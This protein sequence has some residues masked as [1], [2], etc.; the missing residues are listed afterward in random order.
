MYL[1]K[2]SGDKTLSL[3]RK[4]LSL[5]IH[6]G[7][8]GN[9]I[10]EFDEVYILVKESFF[11]LHDNFVPQVPPQPFQQVLQVG[12]VTAKVPKLVLHLPIGLQ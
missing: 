9:Q 6:H 2:V 4:F 7:L 3:T 5:A 11:F 1:D 12:T 8:T 10:L